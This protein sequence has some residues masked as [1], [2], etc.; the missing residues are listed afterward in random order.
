MKLCDVEWCQKKAK[1]PGA[2]YCSAHYEERRK[3]GHVLSLEERA[4]RRQINSE[5]SRR[6]VRS[7]KTIEGLERFL[8]EK[9]AN[10]I[11][12]LCSIEG[13]ERPHAGHGLCQAH[14]Y[15]KK[16]FG[17]PL[18]GPT[19]PNRGKG[20]TVNHGGYVQLFMPEHHEANQRGYVME[21]R[22]V[23]EKTAGRN[24]LPG[25]V[26]HH[27]NGNRGDNRPENLELFASH[28]EHVKT[29]NTRRREAD[30]VA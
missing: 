3:H 9:R 21:H 12:R 15:K 20:R 29:E 10:R 13:C 1:R 11:P 16:K 18:V 14:L 6:L 8:A 22:V 25:E 2:K 28:S 30:A 27:I 23:M 4:E 19:R 17:D 26:V 7:P 24:L 5:R